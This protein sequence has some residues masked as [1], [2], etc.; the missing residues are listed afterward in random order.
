[1]T[2]FAQFSAIAGYERIDAEAGIIYGVSVITAGEAKGRHHGTW[3]DDVTISQLHSIASKCSGGIKVKLSMSKEHDGSLGQVCAS[4]KSFRIDGNKERADLYLL[5]SDPHFNKILELAKAMPTE[6]GLSANLGTDWSFEKKDG[7]NFL[8]CSGIESIDL[9]EAPATNDG[10]FSAKTN[11]LTMSAIKYVKGDSGDHAKDC[12]CKECTSKHSKKEMTAMF[13]KI[14]GL[15]E[16]ATEDEISTTFKAS[17]GDT[18]AIAEL[19][20]K[21]TEATTEL[22]A[23]KSGN[24]NALALSKKAEI[25]N[26]VTEASREGKI[27]PL[28]ADDLYTSKDGIV[29][30]KT[31][32]TQ[33]SKM[34][35]KL[36]KGQV[37]LTQNREIPKKADGTAITDRHSPEFMEFAR[38]KRRQGAIELGNMI[39]SNQTGL[40]RN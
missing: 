13:A 20:R 40:T 2:E 14:V 22:A 33:L 32:P 35:S 36:P 37:K 23:L 29:T 7:K 10:L 18:T 31:E 26:L 9:V 17:K 21:V 3:I 27:I 30:I 25:D 16:T 8:R 19:T 12:D 5:K 24:A 6:F 39:L 34:L 11:E 1:M 15:P 28:D 4:L 38:E